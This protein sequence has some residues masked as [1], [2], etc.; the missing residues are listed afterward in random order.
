MTAEEGQAFATQQGLL[1]IE[2]SARQNYNVDVAFQRIIQEIYKKVSSFEGPAANVTTP[3]Q[4]VIRAAEIL[5]LHPL[6]RQVAVAGF[7]HQLRLRPHEIGAEG[8]ED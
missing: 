6:L 2:T 5:L 4:S 8:R 3:R 7:H 1:F